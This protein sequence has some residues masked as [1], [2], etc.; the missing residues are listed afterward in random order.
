MNPV[1][2]RTS[3][4]LVVV[5][6]GPTGL[7]AT[8]YAGFRGLSVLLLDA[9]HEPG[10]QV[11]ALYP[12]KAIH[13]VAGFPAVPGADLVRGLVAQAEAHEPRMVFGAQVV[14]LVRDERSGT[15]T[16]S[17]ADGSQVDARAAVLST[18]VG[19]LRPRTLPVGHGWHGRGVAYTVGD[20]TDHTDEDVVVIG[21][22]DSALDWAL[23]LQPVARSV[24]VVHR[25]RAFRAHAASV[26]RAEKCGVRLLTDCEL[27]AIHGD[28]SV[29]SV[30][31]RDR[32]GS[33]QELPA[34]TVVGALGLV[35]APSPF[36]AWGLELVDRKLV[37]DQS[38]ATNIPGVFAAGDATS[39][40]GKVPLMAVGFG[41]A[42]TAVNNAAVH[43]DPEL[44]L[45]PGHST[46]EEQGTTMAS[47]PT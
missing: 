36:A 19:G 35:T 47:D 13:D 5:G 3:C 24:T 29:R 10:G 37:V 11:T 32:D 38:M 4:D 14:D 2:A 40:P 12:T 43:I 33:E 15:L 27:L 31:L 25:R 44:S 9:Q 8:Y 17:L 6:A 18:G 41:E 28:D 7:F 22:G 23:Q 34:T 39:Y 30:V 16:L 26:A 21:G 45:F 1:A 46:D 42:A 20:P